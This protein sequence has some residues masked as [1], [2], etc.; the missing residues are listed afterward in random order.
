MPDLKK[1]CLKD[2]NL[3]LAHDLSRALVDATTELVV[4]L[5]SAI[6]R[7]LK[8][9]ITDLPGLDPEWANLTGYDAV[10]NYIGGTH[11]SQSGLYY[12]IADG[13]WLAVV[14]ERGLWFGVSCQKASYPAR[15]DEL[16]EGLSNVAGGRRDQS[17]PWYCYPTGSP[18]I[19]NLNHDSLGLLMSEELRTE[20][21][22]SVAGA[23][24][25][26]WQQIKSRG[27]TEPG[28]S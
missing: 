4:D 15:H 8:N 27:L 14:A 6:D 10:N 20:F 28:P 11:A 25:E 1:L 19:R 17:A 26:V 9:T 21:A 16:R 12:P 5:W 24:T 23:I 13:A 18:D 2:D 22:L 3:I 7:A